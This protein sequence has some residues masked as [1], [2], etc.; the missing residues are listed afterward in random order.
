[1]GELLPENVEQAAHAMALDVAAAEVV[2]ALESAGIACVV[3]K[4]PGSAHWLFPED[5]G[6]RVYTDIDLLVDPARFHAAE[7]ELATLGFRQPLSGYQGHSDEWADE[8][9]WE[10]PGSPPTSIDLHRGFHGVGHREAFWAAVDAHTVMLEVAGTSVRIPDAAG[11]ALVTALHESAAGR[12]EQSA[13]DVRRALVRFDDET[14]REAA[15][16]AVDSQALPSF[17]L[18]LTLHPAGRDLVRRLDLTPDLPV[19]VA[20]RSLVTTG[21]DA[22]SV[23]RVWLLQHRWDSVSGWRPRIRVMVD[24]VFPSAEYLR[25]TRPLARRNR[26]GLM[27]VRVARPIALLARAP[28]VLKL[29]VSGHWRSRHHR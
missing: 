25:A 10:R 14:W 15:Q 8:S 27:A 9:A 2:P 12:A 28:G 20:I 19:D 26:L 24:A 29:L 16:R 22:E 23:E 17:V 5:P 18:G 6:Q 21:A 11:C 1:M 4:G 13:A 3:L 7:A